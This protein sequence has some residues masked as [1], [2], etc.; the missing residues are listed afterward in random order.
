MLNYERVISAQ[1][2]FDKD[3]CLF[4]LCLVRAKPNAT[5]NA[6]IGQEVI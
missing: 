2:Q 4:A 1:L 5:S 6:Y 3:R